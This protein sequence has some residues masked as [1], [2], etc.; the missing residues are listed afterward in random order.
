MIGDFVFVN[1]KLLVMRRGSQISSGS[2]IVGGRASVFL[3]EY[4]VVSYGC[5]ILTAT[6]T[7]SGDFMADAAPA[8]RRKIKVG[9]VT[10]G[11]NA[12][13]GAHSVLAP[14]VRIGEGAV[15]GALSYVSHDVPTWSIGWGLPWKQISERSQSSRG[16]GTLSRKTRSDHL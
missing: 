11:K 4:A 14:G 13:I 12:F 9:K 5:T 1:C 3:G 8:S 16:F 10:I 7:P 2:R 15:V 6:D